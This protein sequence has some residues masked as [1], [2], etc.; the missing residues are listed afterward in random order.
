MSAKDNRHDFGTNLSV[1]LW[2]D[3]PASIHYAFRYESEMPTHWDDEA[4][5]EL[6][7]CERSGNS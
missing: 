2:Y 5:S 7:L 3:T 1:I 4:R 6:G